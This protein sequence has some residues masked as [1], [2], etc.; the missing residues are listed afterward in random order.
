MDGLTISRRGELHAF[1]L[2]RPILSVR[3]TM[4]MSICNSTTETISS[5]KLAHLYSPADPTQGR[6][7]IC[8]FDCKL[9]RLSGF[10]SICDKEATESLGY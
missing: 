3:I 9:D 7:R 1:V 5:T 10:V 8:R 6:G 4:E 2:G